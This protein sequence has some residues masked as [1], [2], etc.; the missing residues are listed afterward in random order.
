MT[1]GAKSPRNWGKQK[2]GEETGNLG[3]KME[4]LECPS[5]LFL[6]EERPSLIWPFSF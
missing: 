2:F 5:A 4:R 3:R 6:V 1:L